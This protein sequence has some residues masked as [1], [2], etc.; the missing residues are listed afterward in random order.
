MKLLFDFLPVV[1]F[2]GTFKYAESQKEWAS[3]TATEYLGL[4]VS[5][6]VVG[7]NEAPILLATVVVM[8]ATLAQVGFLLLRR[9]KVD[10][11]LWVSLALVVLLGGA[12]VWL[13]SDTFIKWKPTVLYWA[14]GLVLAAA[15]G[16]FKNNLIQR[17]LSDK[18][19]VSASVW[20]R[21]NLAWILFF[22]LMGGLNL[23]VAFSFSSDTWVNFKLFGVLGLTLLFT[24]AQGVYLSRHM[25]QPASHPPGRASSP[26]I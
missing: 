26:D 13:H 9:Q 24:L 17:L 23:L 12:T 20:A 19:E 1:L 25:N 5:G 14:M 8:I 4:W 11:M 15:A 3:A 16:F 18:V 21:L 22:L 7:P 6:G 10:T 2:F